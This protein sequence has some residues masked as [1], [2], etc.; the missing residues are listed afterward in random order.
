MLK[1]SNFAALMRIIIAFTILT[2]WIGHSHSQSFDD[3]LVVFNSEFEKE[4]FVNFELN[5]IINLLLGL[6]PSMSNSRSELVKNEIK[7]ISDKL[8]AKKFKEQSHKNQAKLLQKVL[9]GKYLKYY[10]LISPFHRIF[11]DGQYNCVSAT[12][13]YACVLKNLK[14]PFIIKEQPT[15]VY[16]IIYPNEERILIETTAAKNNYDYIRGLNTANVVEVLVEN[17]TLRQSYV[18]SVGEQKAF[19]DYFFTDSTISI[20]QLIGD[21]Y[22]NEALINLRSEDTLTAISSISKACLLHPSKKNVMMK[23]SILET[24]LY[25]MKFD[26]FDNLSFLK[27]YCNIDNASR[28]KIQYKFSNFLE[29]YLIVNENKKMIDSA[30]I[31]LLDN[32]RIDKHRN[33]IKELYYIGLS[34]YYSGA[35]NYE[36]A[37]ESILKAVKINP[38]EKFSIGNAA[39]LLSIH[40]ASYDVEAFYLLSED[41]EEELS[42]GE[43]RS[44][45]LENYLTNYPKLA[46]TSAIKAL[47]V[48]I[49]AQCA[50]EQFDK[51]NEIKALEYMNLAKLNLEKIEDQDL[52]NT[53][54]NGDMYSS[55]GAFYFRKGKYQVALDYIEEGLIIAPKHPRLLA[56]QRIIQDRLEGN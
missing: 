46:E 5:P 24:K 3:K 42:D 54:Y 44:L 4:C 29:T 11:E 26:Q 14:I 20:L 28:K 56:K 2:C 21:Q 48:Y 49:P 16:I 30:Y 45:E 52:I 41:S 55:A 33:T 39:R 17:E 47:R 7:G 36:K 35:R 38:E 50:Q 13:L 22:V 8:L 43:V 51:N 12:A 23:Q 40:I 15:H 34:D 19:N 27:E 9:H 1:F 10:S 53:E 31:Y 25:S 32:I 6:D 18:D 37:L